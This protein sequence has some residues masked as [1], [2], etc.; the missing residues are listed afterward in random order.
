MAVAVTNTS[1]LLYDT[2]YTVTENAAT[3]TVANATEAFTITPTAPGHDCLLEITVGPTNGAVTYSIAAG[4]QWANVGALTGSV[5][6][7]AT[8]CIVLESAKHLSATGTY[9]ITFTPATDKKLL[10]DHALTVQAIEM[11]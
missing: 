11:P 7:D 4:A 1:V 8:E 10:T 5:A 2:E 3:S 9:V 6:Q